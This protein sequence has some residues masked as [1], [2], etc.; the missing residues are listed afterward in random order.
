MAFETTGLRD[1]DARGKQAKWHVQVLNIDGMAEGLWWTLEE[2][3]R[4]S[5]LRLA[6]R[7]R[8]LQLWSPEVVIPQY[9]KVYE[10]AIRS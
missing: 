8:A 10:T 9:L 3:E 4:R 5:T 1:T 7:G 6:V 2:S